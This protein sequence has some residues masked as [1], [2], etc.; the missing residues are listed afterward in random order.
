YLAVVPTYF[1]PKTVRSID[2]MDIKVEI[3]ANKMVLIH[4]GENVTVEPIQP[5][6]TTRLL[7]G[8][9]LPAVECLKSGL[10]EIGATGL[11]KSKPILHLEVKEMS[12]GG[13][14]EVEQ[15]CLN[16]MA[17]AAGARKVEFV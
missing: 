12:E 13:L 14:S 17:Y 3:Y 16:E 9:F 6:T 11:F 5:Y 8:T 15:R 1:A 4:R 2:L 7:V 10:R